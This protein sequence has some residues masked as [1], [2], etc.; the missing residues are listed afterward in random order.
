MAARLWFKQL[1][2]LPLTEDETELHAFQQHMKLASALSEY[3]LGAQHQAGTKWILTKDQEFAYDLGRLSYIVE[4]LLTGYKT[5]LA[6]EYAYAG[7]YVVITWS[8]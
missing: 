8:K 1:L 7:R 2:S 5:H 3:V 4:K 6:F